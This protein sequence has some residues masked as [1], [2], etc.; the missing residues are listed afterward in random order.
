MT[1]ELGLITALHFI[2]FTSSF[3]RH[4][5]RITASKYKWGKTTPLK[6]DT[7]IRWA[8]A[9]VSC[10]LESIATDT[11]YNGCQYEHN[12]IVQLCASFNCLGSASIGSRTRERALFPGYS[13]ACSTA[14]I[15]SARYGCRM[16]YARRRSP[17]PCARYTLC[18]CKIYF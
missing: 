1:I 4:G 10:M 16:Q 15:S 12:L 3:I 6:R 11:S 17:P 18:T 9:I 8:G 7:R 13:S 14:Y 5:S 2:S